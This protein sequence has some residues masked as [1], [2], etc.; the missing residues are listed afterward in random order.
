VYYDN[1]FPEFPNYDILFTL[2]IFHEDEDYSIEYLQSVAD[3]V[4]ENWDANKLVVERTRRSKRQ[5]K[6]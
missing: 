1:K 2:P 6:T 3:D 5:K 4:I